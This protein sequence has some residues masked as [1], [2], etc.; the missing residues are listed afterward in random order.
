M[1]NVGGVIHTSLES[2]VHVREGGCA[3]TET[4]RFAKIVAA[5]PTETAVATHDPSLDCHALPDDK[6]GDT[7]ADGSYNARGFM[8]E[9]KRLADGK[10]AVTAMLVVMEIAAAQ[11]SGNDLDLDLSGL[12]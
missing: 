11:A 1:Y 3:A 6:A 8:A 4:H 2:T 9:Y 5:A 12:G 7:S 10:V